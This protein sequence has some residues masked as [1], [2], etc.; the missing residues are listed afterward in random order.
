MVDE[1]RSATIPK[2][3]ELSQNYPNP[4]NPSTQFTFSLYHR[5]QVEVLVYNTLGQEVVKL[6]NE[7]KN[8]GTY[9]VTFTNN[10]LASGIY[11]YELRTPSFQQVK[12]LMLLK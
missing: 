7:V 2:G 4:F 6:V 10:R 12:S 8:S 5:E 11:S 3:A 1:I 9:R